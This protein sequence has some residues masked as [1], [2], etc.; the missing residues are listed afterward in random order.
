M[1]AL[2]VMSGN[3]NF[4]EGCYHLNSP[5]TRPFPGTLISSGTEVQDIFSSVLYSSTYMILLTVRI[6]LIRRG[7]LT[8]ASSAFP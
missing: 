8:P 2:A 6:T 3:E 1:H 5:A 4:L 7:T